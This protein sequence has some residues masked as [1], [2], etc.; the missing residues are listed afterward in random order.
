MKYLII[1]L[2]LFNTAKAQVTIGDTLTQPVAFTLIDSTSYYRVYYSNWT[3]KQNQVLWKDV[4]IPKDGHW[5]ELDYKG[6]QHFSSKGFMVGIVVD[7]FGNVEPIQYLGL[8]RK[9]FPVPYVPMGFYYP[10]EGT[11]PK[12]QE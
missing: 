8:D 1:I 7:T 3:V 4:R 6:G 11:N 9:P 12:K 5:E 2:F 10:R